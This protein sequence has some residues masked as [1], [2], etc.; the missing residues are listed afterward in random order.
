[1]NVYIDRHQT[2]ENV[3]RYAATAAIIMRVPRLLA[4]DAMHS[5]KNGKADIDYD[6]CVSCGGNT[7]R[8]AHSNNLNF[9]SHPRKNEHIA[10]APALS[11]DSNRKTCARK[12]VR[13]LVADVRWR[14][15]GCARPGAGDFLE[16]FGHLPFSN[17]I[18]CQRMV[19]RSEK[20]FPD[21]AGYISMALTLTDQ[22]PQSQCEVVFYRTVCSKKAGSDA[23]RYPGSRFH[24]DAK[25]MTSILRR[26]S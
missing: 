21:Y 11:D 3:R 23:R 20:L 26:A 14:S 18:C 6:R 19:I 16:E 22:A 9:Q 10:L 1:M 5:D 12:T 24:S 4:V 8:S 25:K 13:R 7:G 15:G 17:G 2:A